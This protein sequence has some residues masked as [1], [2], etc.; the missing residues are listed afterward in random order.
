MALWALTAPPGGAGLT[1]N[2]VGQRVLVVGEG[3]CIAR[4]SLQ[5]RIKDAIARRYDAR[6]HTRQ[7]SR[8]RNHT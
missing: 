2:Q 1:A 4:T 3:G 5:D 6:T 8:T 7:H